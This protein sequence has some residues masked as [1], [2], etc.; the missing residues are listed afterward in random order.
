MRMNPRICVHSETMLP[1]TWPHLLLGSMALNATTQAMPVTRGN[2]VV[3]EGRANVGSRG[4]T[5]SKERSIGP[6]RP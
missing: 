3:P 4:W 2:K 5:S 1:R 6:R